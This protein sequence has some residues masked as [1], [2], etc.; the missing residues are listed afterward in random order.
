MQAFPN[1]CLADSGDFSGLRPK[2]FGI[3][4]FGIGDGFFLKIRRVTA[5]GHRGKLT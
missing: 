4:F 1:I 5:I 2:K 3:V